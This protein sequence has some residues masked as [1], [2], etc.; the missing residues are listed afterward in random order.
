M[1]YIKKIPLL[2][3]FIP[4]SIFAY[5]DSDFDGVED[6]SDKCPNTSPIDLV[7]ENGCPKTEVL[8]PSYHFDIIVGLKSIKIT[9]KADQPNLY[10][11]INTAQIDY[12]YKNFSV[13][14]SGAKNGSKYEDTYVSVKYKYKYDD[15][16]T[17]YTSLQAALPT[18]KS[19]LNN[20]RTDY[21]VLQSVYYKK[22]KVSL[23]GAYRFTLV[24]DVDVRKSLICYQNT[25]SYTIGTGW[26]ITD[27]WYS[28]VSI[29]S[30]ESSYKDTSSSKSANIYFLYS[31]DK[32]WFTNTSF[33]K[34]YSDRT[35]SDAFSL[36]LGYY[37]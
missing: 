30:V 26:D 23:F 9:S 14:L 5:I 18:Y 19:Y 36:R 20:N 1:I 22:D 28:S 33:T 4:I 6:M 35:I 29:S 15:K 8:E 2:M 37:Y 27:K 11:N 13:N 31:F 7:D 21:S 32:N 16:L 10:L 24:N 34:T 12:F 17:F 25:N 3:L